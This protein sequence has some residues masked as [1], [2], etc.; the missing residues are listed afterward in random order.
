MNSLKQGNGVKISLK[1][2]PGAYHQAKYQSKTA[3]QSLD[4]KDKRSSSLES[5]EHRFKFMMDNLY[6]WVFEMM[7]LNAYLRHYLNSL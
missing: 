3:N 7:P 6:Y 2:T 1:Q 4:L 5:H